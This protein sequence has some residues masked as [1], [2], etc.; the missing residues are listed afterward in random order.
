MGTGHMQ[1]GYGVPER[2]QDVS[3]DSESEACMLVHVDAGSNRHI[4]LDKEIDES[5]EAELS[6]AFGSGRKAADYCL[7]TE[8]WEYDE[9][10]QPESELAKDAMTA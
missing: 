7:V 3:L 4:S 2:L 8:D 9:E 1:Y 5:Y 10:E 6:A